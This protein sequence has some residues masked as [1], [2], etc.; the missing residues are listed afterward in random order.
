MLQGAFA[1]TAA[2]A[3]Q[4]QV[5]WYQYLG[6]SDLMASV[7]TSTA[8]VGCIIGAFF[9]GIMSDWLHMAFPSHGRIVFGQA[10]DCGK[11]II[12]GMVLVT[13]DSSHTDTA[14]IHVA[15]CSLSFFFGFVSIMGYSAVVKPIFVE[16]V[17]PHLIAQALGTAAAVDGA[18]A[19]FAGGPLVGIITQHIFGYQDTFLPIS[20]MPFQL[21]RSNAAALGRA[22]VGVAAACTFLNLMAFGLL[23]FTYPRDRDFALNCS[24][25][26]SVQ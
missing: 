12:L 18:F 26:G 13:C 23:H 6:Y 24:T 8:L 22:I 3:M 21:R 4:Y 15:M 19:S 10:V 2:R 7:I 20:S 5:M 17:Q 25:K 14:G 16:I 11:L 9:G 1:S